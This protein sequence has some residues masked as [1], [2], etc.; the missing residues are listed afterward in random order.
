MRDPYASRF[1]RRLAAEILRRDNYRCQFRL[2]G[3]KGRATAAGHIRD[4]RSGGPV[5]DPT[6]LAASCVSCNTSERNSRIAR[7]R[8]GRRVQPSRIW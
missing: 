5:Y 3:C 6:N 7:E 1:W 8:Q 4:W 2:P